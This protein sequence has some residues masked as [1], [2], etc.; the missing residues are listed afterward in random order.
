MSTVLGQAQQQHGV[1]RSKGQVTAARLNSGIL[2]QPNQAHRAGVAT[3]TRCDQS[4]GTGRSVNK[5]PGAGFP[6]ISDGARTQSM[7][8][9]LLFTAVGN[10]A[11]TGNRLL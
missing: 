6:N 7:M 3:G 1:E 9:G 11:L 10:H 8:A 5:T 2:L 4:R